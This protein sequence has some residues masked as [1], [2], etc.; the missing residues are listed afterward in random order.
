MRSS[1]CYMLSGKV[2]LQTVWNVADTMPNGKTYGLGLRTPAC[3]VED[4]GF[5]I[6]NWRRNL[7]TCGEGRRTSD[8]QV[9]NVLFSLQVSDRCCLSDSSYLLPAICCLLAGVRRQGSAEVAVASKCVEPRRV[10][11]TGV[12]LHSAGCAWCSACDALSNVYRM[13]SSMR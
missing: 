9:E 6:K 1:V 2:K 4:V 5:M 8:F 12:L 13:L 3:E 10:Y 11:T 7:K